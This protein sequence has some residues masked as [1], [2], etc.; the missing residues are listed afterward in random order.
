[1]WAFVDESGDPGLRLGQGSSPYF[2]VAFVVFADEQVMQYW[3][4]RM[5]ELRGHLA[6]R[7]NE[8]HFHRDG[9]RRR[10]QLLSAVAS[11]QFQLFTL[12]IDKRY[13]V[14]RVPEIRPVEI[15]AAACTQVARAIDVPSRG[16]TILLDDRQDR[17]EQRYLSK[18]LRALHDETGASLVRRVRFAS[19]QGSPL[20][21]LA[22]YCAGIAYRSA[23]NPGRADTYAQFLRRQWKWNRVIG[24]DELY[25]E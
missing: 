5:T 10:Q 14:N 22:D 19:S 4:R 24:L 12:T 20:I 15:Y 16:C 18:Q 7:R 17:T 13:R 23:M 3:Q 21:Q 25:P 1:V 2:T 11:A 9:H 8:F 6:A